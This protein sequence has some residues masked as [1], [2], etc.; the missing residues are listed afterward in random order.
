MTVLSSMILSLCQ[1]LYLL[2]LNLKLLTS[3][4]LSCAVITL[5]IQRLLSLSRWMKWQSFELT[6]FFLFS[7]SPPVNC[8]QVFNTA[9]VY[10]TWLKLIIF[11]R[12]FKCKL[13]LINKRSDIRGWHCCSNEV[14]VKWTMEMI[15]SPCAEKWKVLSTALLCDGV[16][17]FEGN[18]TTWYLI[19]IAKFVLRDVSLFP[20]N[21]ILKYIYP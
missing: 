8:Q 20:A 18:K 16:S 21:I 11:F 5:T 13:L 1:V 7:F 10:I 2:W 9:S 4:I 12:D 19:S 3:W 6:Y 15:H 17:S 14:V